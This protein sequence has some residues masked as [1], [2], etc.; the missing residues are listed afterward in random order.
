M[1][2]KCQ[3]CGGCCGQ[4]HFQLKFFKKF[5]HL[6][7]RE[8][9][10]RPWPGGAVMPITPNGN[11]VFLDEDMSCAIYSNRP[12]VCRQYGL[13]PELPCPHHDPE[14]YAVKMKEIEETVEGWK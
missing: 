12:E 2:F 9:D 11:C 5:N 8:Y 3:R 14:A 4:I 1:T 13:I 10:L 6:T 7:K